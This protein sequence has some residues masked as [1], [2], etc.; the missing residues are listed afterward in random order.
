LGAFFYGDMT[1]PS[2]SNGNYALPAGYLAVGGDTI[3]PSQHNPPLEDVAAGLTA[4]LMRSGAGG[5]TGQLKATDGAV[6]APSYTFGTALTTGFYKTTGGVGLSIGGA[7]AAEFGPSGLIYNDQS[8]TYPKI[9]APSA[10][11]RLLG[12]NANAALT[13]T[14]AANNGSGLIRLTVAST[15]TFATGQKKIVAGVTGTTEANGRWTITVVDATHIDLQGSAFTNAYVSGGTIGGGVDEIKISTGLLL[16]GDTLTATLNPTLVPNYLS[17]LTMSTIGGSGNMVIA[18]GAAND[19]TNTSLMGFAGLTKTTSSWI[20]G[21]G[22]GLDTGAIGNNAWY[23]FYLIQRPD[24]GAVDAIFSLSASAPALPPSYTLYR[25]IG[26][27]KTDG[28][29]HWIAFLQFG[30]DFL[31]L[32]PITGDVSTTTLTAAPTSFVLGGVPTGVRVFAQLTGIFSNAAAYTDL[33]IQS[34]DVP[35]AGPS[36]AGGLSTARNPTAGV[37]IAFAATIRTNPSA[38]IVAYSSLANSTL[39]VATRGWTDPRGK[40]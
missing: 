19:T 17:G 27:G 36:A 2:D 15:S 23:H 10:A 14:A 11:S 6:G 22:G 33:L 28:S 12:S 25:R 4:R 26:S 13:I 9:V 29:A 38:Q 30:D 32:S 18:S 3:L 16:S 1:L 21:N 35:G 31:W 20:V 39:I 8:V 7:L 40:I 37:A 24:T 5:M 34:S